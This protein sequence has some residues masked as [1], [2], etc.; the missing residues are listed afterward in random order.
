MRQRYKLVKG[1][2]SE[3]RTTFP[4]NNPL[5]IEVGSL[6]EFE[7]PHNGQRS[8]ECVCECVCVSECVYLLGRERKKSARVE[9]SLCPWSQALVFEYP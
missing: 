6:W 9:N 5:A 1:I 2:S 8:S 4:V 3:G 7:S